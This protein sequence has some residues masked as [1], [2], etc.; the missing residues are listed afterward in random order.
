M[1]RVSVAIA[2]LALLAFATVAPASALSYLIPYVNNGLE[3]LDYEG[4]LIKTDDGY[5]PWTTYGQ[6]PLPKEGDIFLGMWQAQSMAFRSPVSPQPASFDI[7]GPVFSGFFGLIVDEEATPQQ[8]SL[9]FRPLTADEWTAIAA[10]VPN[11]LV[12]TVNW[13]AATGTGSVGSIWSDNTLG[14]ANLFITPDKDGDETASAAD[15][16]EDFATVDGTMLWEV[17]FGGAESLGNDRWTA[18]LNAFEPT[19]VEWKADLSVTAYGA[20]PALLYTDEYNHSGMGSPFFPFTQIS[21]EGKITSVFQSG[22][23]F[24]NTDTDVYLKPTP[25]PGS[26]AL[27]GLGLAALGGVVYRRRRQK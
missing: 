24:F 20:G 6:I 19:G 2:L 4:V 17:G 14:E 8:L 16:N 23:M 15:W 26:L 22:D 11:H 12:P 18:Y 25:E 9:A 3:D 27:L 21:L 13:N 7:N 10:Y 1:R 5:V